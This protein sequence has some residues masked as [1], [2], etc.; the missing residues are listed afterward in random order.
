LSWLHCQVFEK[1][2]EKFI[3]INTT[4]LPLFDQSAFEQKEPEGKEVSGYTR[5]PRGKTK[6]LGNNADSGL[7]F[8]DGVEIVVEDIYP[9]EIANLPED[10]YEVIGQEVSDRLASVVSRT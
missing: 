9:K 5:K 6:N 3:P 2:S 4:P 7:R 8:D 10:A 1:T